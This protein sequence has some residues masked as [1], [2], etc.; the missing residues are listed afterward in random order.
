MLMYFVAPMPPWSPLGPASD[1]HLYA[2]QIWPFIHGGIAVLLTTKR[3]HVIAFSILYPIM[4]GQG[5]L[6]QPSFLTCSTA[7]VMD[8]Q[9]GAIGT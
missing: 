7:D 3:R 2:I 9:G 8:H 1:C 4:S 5:K 6:E